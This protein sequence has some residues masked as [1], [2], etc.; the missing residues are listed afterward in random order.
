MSETGSDDYQS[1][2]SS[3][4]QKLFE[5]RNRNTELQ[6]QLKLAHKCIQQEVGENFN[7]N[8][9]ASHASLSQW[10]GRAQQILHLQQKVQELRERLENYE[11]NKSNRIT[12]YQQKNEKFSKSAQKISDLPPLVSASEL[13]AEVNAKWSGG[14]LKNTF[15]RYAPAVRKSEIMHRAKVEELEMEI[16][17][18]KSEV[19]NHKAKILALKVRNKNLG[20]EL[21]KQKMKAVS[22]D[23]Q[24]DFNGL[25]LASMN[26][27]LNTQR[28]EYE[29]RIEAL[30]TELSQIEKQKESAAFKENELR[31]LME[32]HAMEL[33]AK[34]E[35]IQ[36]LQ[37]MLTKS[38]KDLKAVCGDFLFSC[39]DL[40][41]VKKK[42]WF[43]DN[44][45]HLIYF[46]FSKL[47]F[48]RSLYAFW[49][50]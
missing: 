17:N 41:K 46:L 15:D 48:R 3:L 43:R 45:K 40:K 5:T 24:S 32:N 11:H 6:A 26:D 31:E 36:K 7:L 10:R 2:V 14:D 37:M 20:E 16:T 33:E 9:L 4:Q 38:E 44:P 13:E 27:K 19:E 25:N 1:R 21:Q 8:I 30:R 42:V 50:L 39:R 35:I 28:Y 29:Q 49:M 34:D 47:Y 22:L 18:L 12:S 23:E